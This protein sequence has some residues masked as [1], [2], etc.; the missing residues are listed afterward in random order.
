MLTTRLQYS[1]LLVLPV[2]CDLII[3]G[4]VI[5][6]NTL[7]T[8]V[9]LL[10]TSWQLSGYFSDFQQWILIFLFAYCAQLIQQFRNDTVF[11]L[12]SAHY[13]V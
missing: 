4:A 9:A 2:A 7:M 1:V 13:A 8:N 11:I 10:T 3:S 12:D 6:H 5:S